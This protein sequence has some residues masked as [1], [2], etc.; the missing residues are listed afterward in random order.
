[1]ILFSVDQSRDI[2]LAQVLYHTCPEELHIMIRDFVKNDEYKWSK[3][4]QL[5]RCLQKEDIQFIKK[6]FPKKQ[7]HHVRTFLSYKW[8]INKVKVFI[9]RGRDLIVLKPRAP[10]NIILSLNRCYFNR[11]LDILP[12][13]TPDPAHKIQVFLHANRWLAEE[14]MNRFQMTE[15]QSYS[16]VKELSP[17]FYGIDVLGQNYNLLKNKSKEEIKSELGIPRDAKIAMLSFRKAQPEF[18]IFESNENFISVVKETLEELKK[19]NYYIIS[20]RRLGKHDIEY[21]KKHKTPDILLFDQVEKFIDK[22]VNGSGDYPDIIWKSLYISDFLFLP[23]ISG[24]CS[25]EA[26]LTRCPV[27]MPF[28]SKE[29]VLEKF[30]TLSPPILDMIQ[31]GLVFNTLDKKSFDHFHINIEEFIHDWFNTDISQFWDTVLDNRS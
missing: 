7:T 23:D 29:E 27:Y 26:A 4:K 21:Y 30:S 19:Q 13:I 18:S 11:I 16:Q 8:L 3:P 20:R 25:C 1:M 2:P 6:Y 10:K 12:K 5:E 24:I 9:T 17:F 28:S 15:E 22:E 14:H 31:R